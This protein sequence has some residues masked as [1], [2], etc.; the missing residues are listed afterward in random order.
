MARGDSTFLREAPQI[1]AGTL[2]QELPAVLRAAVRQ[3]LAQL[4]TIGLDPG[5][6]AYSF[7]LGPAISRLGSG[8]RAAYDHSRQVTG[9][10]PTRFFTRLHI[11]VVL[12]GA[13]A[14]L[15][16][17]PSPSERTARPFLALIITVAVGLAANAAVIAALATVHPRYQ[18]RVV[19]L[20][21]LL[22]AAAVA[23]SRATRAGMRPTGEGP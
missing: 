21:P 20:V 13:L 16:S 18:S 7:S 17:L 14:L 9:T 2:R 3:A 10:V 5:E 6:H 12:G 15:L 11:G 4:V 19:W 22:G 8:V 23:R 1:V